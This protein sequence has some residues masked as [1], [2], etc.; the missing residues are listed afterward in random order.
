MLLLMLTASIAES[1]LMI[2]N[3]RP[4]VVQRSMK[5]KKTLG[6]GLFFGRNKS[7]S[8]SRAG[9]LIRCGYVLIKENSGSS[10]LN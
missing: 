7:G 8:E 1:D 6:K 9:K 2:A 10:L 4:E 3:R 5:W